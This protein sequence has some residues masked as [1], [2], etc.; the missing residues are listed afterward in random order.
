M[1]PDVLSFAALKSQTM[2]LAK[3]RIGCLRFDV[4]SEA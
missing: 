1:Y 4:H 3:R 2:Y